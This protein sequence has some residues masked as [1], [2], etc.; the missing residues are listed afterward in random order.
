MQ[1]EDE[2][3]SGTVEEEPAYEDRIESKPTRFKKYYKQYE[4]T[5]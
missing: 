2:E 4:L 3:T 5:N 1:I